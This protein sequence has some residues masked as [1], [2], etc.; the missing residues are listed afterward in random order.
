MNNDFSILAQFLENLGPEVS[1]HSSAT[2]TAEEMEQIQLFAAGKLD[3][4]KRDEILPSILGNEKALHQLV[5][6]LRSQ[7]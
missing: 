7:G 1:G 5:E 4:A 6:Q 3:E 2:L